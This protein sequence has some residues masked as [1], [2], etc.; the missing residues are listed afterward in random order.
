VT[1]EFIKGTDYTEDNKGTQSVNSLKHNILYEINNFIS[2]Y[3]MLIFLLHK[4]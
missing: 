1:I 2:I 4:I 3:I